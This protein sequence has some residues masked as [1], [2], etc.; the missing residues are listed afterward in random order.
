MITRKDAARVLRVL[1]SRGGVFA[2]VYAQRIESTHVSYDDGRL[3]EAATGEDA[4]VALRLIRGGHTHFANFNRLDAGA[5]LEE[6]QALARA[7]FGRPRRVAPPRLVTP[8]TPDP[9]MVK[10]DPRRVPLGHKVRVVRRCDAAARGVDRRVVQ[11]TCHYRDTTVQVR[12][13]NSEGRFVSDHRVSTA[14]VCMAVA[15]EGSQTR[16]GYHPAA[17]ACG[18]ELLRRQTPEKIGRE[19][20][21]IAV[22]QL[23]A[24]PAPA[25]TFTVVLSSSAGGTM[26]HEACGHGLEGDFIMKNLSVYAGK[27]GQKVA[28]GLITVVDDGTLPNRCGSSRIDDEGTPSTRALLIEDGVLKGYL[29]SWKTARDLGHEPT[30]HGRRESYR[31]LPIPRMRNTLILPGSSDPEEILRSVADGVFVARMGGGEV[32][33]ATGN[34]V[35]ACTE[36]YRIR[37]GKKAEPLRDATLIGNGIEVL[38]SIDQVGWDLG[39]GVGTCGKDGQGVPVAD[40]QPTLRIPRITVGGTVARA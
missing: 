20:A 15:R 37:G 40:A 6:A 22:L 39:Y 17:G 36:A 35:F 14:L 18:F 24:A 7:S 32:D 1:L 13:A 26:I 23:E 2:E 34:F 8:R 28:S 19:A 3:D 11:V 5:I 25:G 21:R 10:I 27:E 9:C 4:G 38:R 30:G 33:I 31:Y 29:H 16:T 12:V